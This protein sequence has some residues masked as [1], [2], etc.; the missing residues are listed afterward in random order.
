MVEPELRKL[1]GAVGNDLEVSGLD[2]QRGQGSHQILRDK[3]I[4]RRH[5]PVELAVGGFFEPDT[6]GPA[7]DRKRANLAHVEQAL[8]LALEVELA[9]LGTI[10]Q[11]V[12]RQQDR[13][14]DGE[15]YRWARAHTK[16]LLRTNTVMPIA[17][18]KAGSKTAPNMNA[19]RACWSLT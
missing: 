19:R 2:K 9:G 15:E 5:D 8:V 12:V 17:N 14:Q 1:G 10:G 16:N 11:N 6:L 3:P 18:I 13:E 7:R 4:G